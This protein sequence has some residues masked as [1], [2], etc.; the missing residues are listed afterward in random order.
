MMDQEKFSIKK[1]FISFI[2]AF[3]GLKILITKEH[4]SRIHLFIAICVIT[5]SFIF[6]INSMEW[7][8]VVLSIGF[9]FFAEAI[10]TVV[11]YLCDFVS[12]QYH[13]QIRKIKD[14]AAAGVLI[15]AMSVFI[16]GLIIF[17]PKFFKIWF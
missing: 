4:N 9:I 13:E 2:F 6:Q 3:S 8:V 15:A 16:S 10:N 5:G 1:R 7:I 14:L 17:V 11:E 12:P